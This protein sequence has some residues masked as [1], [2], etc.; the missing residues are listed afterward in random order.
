M[1]LPRVRFTVR[2]MMTAV[3]FSAV[4]LWL[5]LWVASWRRLRGEYL[6]RAER[7]EYIAGNLRWESQQLPMSLRVGYFSIDFNT[8]F[9]GSRMIF[10][11]VQFQSNGPWGMR[12][13]EFRAICSKY[14]EACEWLS[15][16]YRRAADYPWFVPPDP[17]PPLPRYRYDGRFV[18][19]R[20]T[21]RSVYSLVRNEM[22]SGLGPEQIRASF[23]DIPGWDGKLPAAVDE[24][25]EDALGSRPS[26]H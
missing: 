15:R 13:T 1:R 16:G 24:A 6:A 26:R 19:V 9:V 8:G 17:D 14:A 3:A 22:A 4:A 23:K 2:R 25:V 7:C 12:A 5:T 10:N 21:Y 11:P 20:E 18:D